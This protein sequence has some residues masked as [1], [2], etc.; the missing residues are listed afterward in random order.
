MSV[1][2]GCAHTLGMGLP[3]RSLDPTAGYGVLDAIMGPR[4]SKGCPLGLDDGTVELR[5]TMCAFL[6]E[7]EHPAE[8]KVSI[9]LHFVR[10]VHEVSVA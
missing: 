7:I 10:N 9:V 6:A 3:M 5:V 2:Q 1:R 8:L 4:Q